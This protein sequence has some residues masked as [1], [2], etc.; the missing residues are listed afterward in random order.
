MGWSGSLLDSNSGHHGAFIPTTYIHIITK[1][2]IFFL[3]GISRA[4]QKRN[5]I[6]LN[7]KFG[8]KSE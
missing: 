4:S 8:S 3:G 6:I 5:K 7:Q 2:M 1:D